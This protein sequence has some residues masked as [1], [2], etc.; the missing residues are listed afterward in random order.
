MIY[1][2]TVFIVDDDPQARESVRVL[3]QSMQMPAQTF[4]SG[5]D[6]L[7]SYD[8]SPG[9]SDCGEWRRSRSSTG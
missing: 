6:F 2:P 8:G 4:E 7:E 5:E 3:V 9:K 1:D